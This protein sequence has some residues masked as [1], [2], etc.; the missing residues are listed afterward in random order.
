METCPLL[1]GP[2][3]LEINQTSSHLL[4]RLKMTS[5]SDVVVFVFQKAALF[6]FDDALTGAHRVVTKVPVR[7]FFSITS[8]SS[9]P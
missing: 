8:L 2:E 4:L 6:T 5:R 1:A 9:S 3:V 7:Y